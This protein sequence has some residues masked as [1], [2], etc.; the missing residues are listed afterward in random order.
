MQAAAVAASSSSSR[1][2]VKRPS[3]APIRLFLAFGQGLRWVLADLAE[4]VF[5][6][7]PA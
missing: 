3:L 5:G 1:R 2:R 7:R 4:R 6:V